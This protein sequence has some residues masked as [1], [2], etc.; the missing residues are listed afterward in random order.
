[1]L[2]LRRDRGMNPVT[3][4]AHRTRFSDHPGPNDHVRPSIDLMRRS[5]VRATEQVLP[6]ALGAAPVR[7]EL[8]TAEAYRKRAEHFRVLA[9]GAV[10]PET[11]AILRRLAAEYEAKAVELERKANQK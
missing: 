11:A 9:I 7:M 8:K 3:S 10:R 5:P 2:N 1:M 4:Q 6:S